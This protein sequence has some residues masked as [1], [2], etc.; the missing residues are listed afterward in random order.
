MILQKRLN[1]IVKP[2][3]YIWALLYNLYYIV[4][5]LIL[6]MKK[7]KIYLGFFYGS[8]QELTKAFTKITD[9]DYVRYIMTAETLICRFKSNKPIN[10]ILEILRQFCPDIPFFVFP[11]STK[12]WQYNLPLDI[13]N[14]LLTDNP[15]IQ[16]PQTK[17][18]NQYFVA[19]LDAIKKKESVDINDDRGADFFDAAIGHLNI[20]LRQAIEEDNFELAAQI[21]D[22]I[23][24]LTDQKTNLNDEQ[25]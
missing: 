8:K 25:T 21:R 22:K 17:V 23:K 6:G 19:M 4:Y 7:K 20:R 15:I 1:N 13:E 11:I 5:S 18:L 12:T 2:F 16:S 9:G 3:E 24:E 14:N 10:E